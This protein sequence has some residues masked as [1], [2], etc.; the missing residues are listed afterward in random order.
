MLDLLFVPITII[1]VLVVGALFIYGLNFFYLTYVAWR[2]RRLVT[3]LA[4]MANWPTVTVQLPIY[5]E[6]YVAERLIEAV[7]GL[8]YPASQLEIQVL[9][10]STDETVQLTR[11]AVERW[12]SRGLNI[13]HLHRTTRPGF[14]AG[15][16]AAGMARAQGEFLAIFDADFVPPPDFL[17]QTIGCFQNPA[18]AFVQTRWGHVNR[19]YSFLTYLQSL[20]IDAHF[21]IEQYARY[22]AG[23]WFNFNGTAGIWRRAAIESAG[24]WQADTLTEDLDLSYRAFLRGWQAVYLRH[25]V[26]PAELPVSFMAY[27]RQQH[28]WARGSLECASKLLPR[29]WAAP[30]SVAVKLG[31]TLHLT[32]Y[33]VH[34]L[35]FAL[36]LLYP[37][38]LLL[39]Q[40]YANLISLF[41]IAAIFNATAFAPTL[42]F[43][44]AQQQL[45][46]RW[47]RQLPVI[48]FITALG[49][50]MMLNTVRAALQIFGN[51]RGAFERTPK[52][53]V[54]NK[55]HDWTRR[56]YQLQLDSLIV[57]ELAFA[58]L[59]LG[60]LVLA[61][62]I[63]NWII[64]VYAAL[65]LAGLL[66]TSGFTVSQAVVLNQRRM[67]PAPA[68][69]PVGPQATPAAPP[70]RSKNGYHSPQSAP[71]PLEQA[72]LRTL[73]Y[74]DI[75]DYPLTAAEI[76]RYLEIP[77][78]PS[79][80]Q[81]ILNNGCLA[82][83]RISRT[84]DYFT[85]P[86]REAVVETR[87]RRAKLAARI[88]PKARCYG[89]WLAYLPFVRMVAITGS[90][91]V[92]NIESGAD[93]DYLI[94]TEPGRLWV[95]RALS[96]VLV[97]LV[98]L[99]GQVICPN[100]FIS[101]NALVFEQRTLYTAHE[102]MQMVPLAGLDVYT[103]ILQL[104]SWAANFLP[105]AEGVLS[106][107][108]RCQ[109]IFQPARRL[110][111]VALHT[112]VGDRLEQWEMNR[113]IRKFSRRGDNHTEIAFC[114]DWCK[115]HFD[116]HEQRVLAAF[117]QRVR[118][119]TGQTEWPEAA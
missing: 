94:V 46:R 16:L 18:V 64:A 55:T 10:D 20:A 108:P 90:L 73:A 21:M 8:D 102:L 28:R 107:E 14:K 68:D 105:N 13:I 100:Y 47:W 96:I 77:A 117:N 119:L 11:S 91:A 85:L 31:A 89:R 84:G 23:L 111:E 30:I 2:N 4:P 32:G 56:R 115:G 26:V 34:L 29:I 57:F 48:L 45:G 12:R 19:H 6:L 1:Y 35:L 97:R 44:A 63:G 40:R 106:P 83:G 118:Y 5:N 66:F 38:V 60:T 82:A 7:A 109:P 71:I 110:A 51:R 76:H 59:N 42:F 3:P 41:G 65:F 99:R 72:V 80:V 43:V 61:L 50:G 25:V 103:R 74:A 98:A 87:L 75:F 104:N 67:R 79:G 101:K 36:V 62:K 15:A 112:P 39:A 33:G 37:I 93:I 70:A 69:L 17:K 88:W 49:A 116:G 27:R 52:F 22:Q 81:A 95:C 9:D 58:L 24:G 78:S 114:R 92:N 86:G 113:K 53:G 54:L